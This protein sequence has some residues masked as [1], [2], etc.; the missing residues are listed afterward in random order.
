MS[1][2]AT[3]S[4]T[5]IVKVPFLVVI[6]TAVWLGWGA[7]VLSNAPP[8]WLPEW[9]GSYYQA[10]FRDTAQSGNLAARG[11]LGDAFGV[12]N[13]LTSMLAFVMLLAGFELQRRQLDAQA[14]QL[15]IALERAR[16]DEFRQELGLAMKTFHRH[17]GPVL[18][19]RR[20]HDAG[21]V[22]AC[23]APLTRMAIDEM[24][25]ALSTSVHLATCVRLYRNQSSRIQEWKASLLGEIE[26][27]LV[28]VRADVR[29]RDTVLA[30]LKSAWEG[31]H[32]K[33]EDEIDAAMRAWCHVCELVLRTSEQHHSDDVQV[34]ADGA[35][36]QMSV[37]ELLFS[38]L[39]LELT[40]ASRWSARGRQLAI[41]LSMFSALS[42]ESDVVVRVLLE[43]RDSPTASS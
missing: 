12:L 30:D 1:P 9:L 29:V 42:A 31:V 26:S 23:P 21:G 22:G 4:Q 11:Q 2:K 36:A 38:F 13:S 17:F 18:S 16:L 27:L 40:E 28:R 5:L 20:S 8:A 33:Y 6:A 25:T 34:Y 37:D 24:Y 43:L 32:F 19:S 35:R 41:G 39:A 7:I 10:S 3:T 15:A 14:H